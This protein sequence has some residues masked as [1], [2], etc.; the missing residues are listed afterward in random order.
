MQWIES[1][2]C[3]F[4]GDQMWECEHFVLDLGGGG[5]DGGVGLRAWGGL[6]TQSD[7]LAALLQLIAFA[8]GEGQTSPTN[9]SVIS[10]RLATVSDRLPFGSEDWWSGRYHAIE[11]LADDVLNAGAKDKADF[12][13]WQGSAEEDP[14]EGSVLEG[15]W[16]DVLLRALQD[17]P[18]ITVG[19]CLVM[20]MTAGT[21]YAVWSADRAAA[22]LAI[23]LAVSS[24][25]A[26]IRDA[27]GAAST[28]GG[29]GA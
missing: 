2:S 14:P 21:Y 6:Q 13:S 20:S 22:E 26:Q 15:L 17:V 10:A 27:V 18:G 4:C 9:G 29:E 28:I 3:P 24:M 11:N 19:D 7:M 16:I 12:M 25:A 8:W 1:C 5:E 23:A